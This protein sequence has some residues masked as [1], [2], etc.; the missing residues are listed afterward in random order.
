MG[1]FLI[2]LFVGL[3]SIVLIWGK[4]AALAGLVCIGLGL[5]PAALIAALL[6][7]LGWI[8]RRANDA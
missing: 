1:F 2:L 5:I 4:D 3:G 7:V 6:W 8:A